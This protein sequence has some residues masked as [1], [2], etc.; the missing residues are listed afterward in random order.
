MVGG[1]PGQGEVYGFSAWHGRGGTL[2]L[3]NPAGSPGA[4]SAS[5]AELML[6]PAPDQDRALR[7]RGVYGVT[8]SLEGEQDAS[9]PLRLELPVLAIAVFEVVPVR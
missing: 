2:A 9:A 8:D 7:L 5:L 1:D 3:R 4:I 6:L